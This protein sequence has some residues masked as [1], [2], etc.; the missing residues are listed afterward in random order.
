MTGHALA[1]V[2]RT[3]WLVT[4]S[5]AIDEVGHS[6]S[7]VRDPR[8]SKLHALLCCSCGACHHVVSDVPANPPICVVVCCMRVG[9]PGCQG[10]AWVFQGVTSC[11]WCWVESL[12]LRA[13]LCP[14]TTVPLCLPAFAVRDSPHRMQHLSYREACYRAYIPCGLSTHSTW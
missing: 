3:V 13:S 6:V 9:V 5:L 12:R 8:Y 2:V 4:S 10:G 11:H 1:K 7:S 14:G